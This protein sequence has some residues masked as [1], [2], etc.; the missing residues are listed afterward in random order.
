MYMPSRDKPENRSARVYK[1]AFTK[2]SPVETRVEISGDKVARLVIA[3]MRARK[4][5]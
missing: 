3:F 2:G 4:S 1:C 5:D